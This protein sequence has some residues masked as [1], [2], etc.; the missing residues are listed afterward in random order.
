MD[1]SG[2]RTG[3]L[4]AKCLRS[5]WCLTASGDGISDLSSGSMSHSIS[6]GK[7]MWM[8]PS[9]DSTMKCI[10]FLCL[11]FQSVQRILFCL[12][13]CCSA[14]QEQCRSS[15]LGVFDLQDTLMQDR[16]WSMILKC[17]HF[18]RFPCISTSQTEW[19]PASAAP[20]CDP[21][22]SHEPRFSMEQDLDVA[23]LG[24]CRCCTPG[25]AQASHSP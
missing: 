12:A 4:S 5:G 20:R 7:G 10:V 1:A 9:N 3:I 13:T 19:L 14:H 11:E 15:W 17:S 25:T 18:H 2:S 16:F 21:R 6:V 8:L 24:V 22:Y 23:L